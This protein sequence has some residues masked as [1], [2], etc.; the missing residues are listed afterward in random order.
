[1]AAFRVAFGP[2]SWLPK[3]RIESITAIATIPAFSQSPG[4]RPAMRR[5]T[6]TG[7]GGGRDAAAD[8][9]RAQRG[10][11]RRGGVAAEGPDLGP[12]VD[13]QRCR[14]DRVARARAVHGP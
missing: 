14:D 7:R 3:T 4:T 8:R 1:M 10:E 6:V 12:A 13:E 5:P 11:R 9:D 2:W